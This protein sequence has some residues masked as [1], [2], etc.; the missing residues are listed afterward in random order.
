VE[1]RRKPD[2][3]R[4]VGA[5]RP[6]LLRNMAFSCAIW[7]AGGDITSR[8]SPRRMSK[9]SRASSHAG[10]AAPPAPRPRVAK[11]MPCD[12]TACAKSHPDRVFRKL[13][14]GRQR[15]LHDSVPK[16]TI[17]LAG[18][19]AEGFVDFA[20]KTALGNSGADGLPETRE[21]CPYVKRSLQSGERI[22]QFRACTETPILPGLASANISARSLASYMRR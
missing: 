9:I 12:G 8:S 1:F 15:L 4:L 7:P 2:R 3:Q 22:L 21:E 13:R 16:R 18:T 6:L 14:G 17:D 20:V 10:V 5:T 11:R 19:S